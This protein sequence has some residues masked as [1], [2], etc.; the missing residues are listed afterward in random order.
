VLRAIALACVCACGRIDFGAMPADAAQQPG[1]GAL[2]FCAQ[3]TGQTFCSD[4]DEGAIG[5][6]SVQMFFGT[7]ALDSAEAKSPPSSLQID[8]TAIPTGSEPD[9][10][11]TKT[12]GQALNIKLAF[13]VFI[14]VMGTNEPILFQLAFDDGAEIHAIELVERVPPGLAYIEDSNTPSGMGPTFGYFQAV[15]LDAGVWHRVIVGYLSGASPQLTVDFDGTNVINTAPMFTT[16]GQLTLQLGVVYS[17]AP[18][19]PWRMHFDNVTLL[20][21]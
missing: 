17:G 8:T 16:A 5:W 20:V 6:D 3:N 18:A 15:P 2:G 7:A 12:F 1:D 13:D 19:A 21:F 10:G 11:V 14:D 9:V 4:F